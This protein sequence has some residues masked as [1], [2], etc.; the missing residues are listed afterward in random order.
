MTQNDLMNGGSKEK[1]QKK[2][3]ML[4]CSSK[5]RTKRKFKNKI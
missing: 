1:N 3:Q 5:K 2:I 4:K